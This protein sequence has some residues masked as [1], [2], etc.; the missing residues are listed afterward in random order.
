MSYNSFLIVLKVKQHYNIMEA[1]KQIERDLE[2]TLKKM[3]KGYGLQ[4]AY[5]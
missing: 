4:D 2:E 3:N 5:E 1:L